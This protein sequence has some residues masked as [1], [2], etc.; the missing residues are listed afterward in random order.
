M[1][2]IIALSFFVVTA[3]GSVA[4]LYDGI[5]EGSF[6]MYQFSME[7]MLDLKVVFRKETDPESGKKGEAD[8]EISVLLPGTRKPIV[9]ACPKASF[10][11]K[12]N[13]IMFALTDKKERKTCTGIFVDA[14]NTVWLENTGEPVISDSKTIDVMY[15]ADSKSLEVN[16]VVPISV[17]FV[18]F[19]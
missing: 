5:S 8:F 7:G 18:G 9:A 16:I 1:F 11:L 10:R 6:P 2:A 3:Q 17:P 13:K 4:G 19:A 12:K 15:V 14:I